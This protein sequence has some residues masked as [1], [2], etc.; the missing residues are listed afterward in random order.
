LKGLFEGLEIASGGTGMFFI[1]LNL[2]T[3]TH[4]HTRFTS[5][6]LLGV[7]HLDVNPSPRSP[8]PNSSSN[9]GEIQVPRL[10]S[11]HSSRL[12]KPKAVPT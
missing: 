4:M 10:E 7:A 2:Q 5:L 11:P 12:P 8:E 6:H 1:S 9:Q 3:D